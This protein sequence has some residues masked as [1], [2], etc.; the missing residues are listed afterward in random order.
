MNTF[1]LHGANAQRMPVYPMMKSRGGYRPKVDGGG[2]KRE[3][4][5]VFMGHPPL[6]STDQQMLKRLMSR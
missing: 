2:S 4:V 1:S 5:A 3:A 6:G